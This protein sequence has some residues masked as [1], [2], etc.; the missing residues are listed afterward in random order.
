M[1][2]EGIRYQLIE[3]LSGLKPFEELNTY[4]E[5][6]DKMMDKMLVLLNRYIS[7]TNEAGYTED[8]SII[9]MIFSYIPLLFDIYPNVLDIY[10]ENYI[11]ISGYYR[12]ITCMKISGKK[13]DIDVK[14][15]LE[16]ELVQLNSVKLFIRNKMRTVPEYQTR[17][18]RNIV[19]SV[20]SGLKEVFQIYLEETF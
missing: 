20:N 9:K 18:I 5:E 15:Y 4:N 13:G 17:K 16:E 12:D 2:T 14:E 1:E 3:S 10:G 7:S 19:N 11:A 6:Q 8:V